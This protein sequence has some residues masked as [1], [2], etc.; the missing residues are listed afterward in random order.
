MTAH[1]M[2]GD[3]DRF[4]A[5]GMDGYVAKPVRPHELYAAVEGLGGPNDEDV[6]AHA[7]GCVLLSGMLRSKTSAATRPCCASLQRC[8]LQSVPS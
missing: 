1:A 5:A 6:T 3:R 7:C 4:L 2:K 8:F